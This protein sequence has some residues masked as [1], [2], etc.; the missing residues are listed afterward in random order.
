M[1]VTVVSSPSTSAPCFDAGSIY[2]PCDLAVLGQC[3]ACS[4]LRGQNSC[5]CGWNGLCVYEEFLRNKKVA[6]PGRRERPVR[7]AGREELECSAGQEAFL[8][9]IC[10]PTEVL[11]WCV[12]P[13]SFALLRPRGTP[14]RFNVPLSVMQVKDGILR[15]AVSVKGPK[16]KALSRACRKGQIVTLVAPFWS[17]LQGLPWPRAIVAGKALGV[18]KGIGQAPL[19]HTA[20]YLLGHGCAFKALLGPGTLGTVFAQDSLVMEGASVE[21][22]PRTKDHNITRIYSE[23]C[24]GDY[25]LLVSVGSDQQHHALLSLIASVDKPPAMA[26]SSNLS[27]TCAQGICGSCLVNGFR[28]CKASLPT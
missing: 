16:T 25:D 7:I 10:A 1:S 22:L 9:D 11:A 15:T 5:D 21:V 24:Q 6:R 3:V 2:C 23:L 27:M 17:G 18:A 14:E 19:L 13:G 4:I 28:G 12:F 26:W 20:K 8:L